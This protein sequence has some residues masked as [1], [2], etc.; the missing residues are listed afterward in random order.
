MNQIS[1]Q[2]H[3]GLL[4]VFEN[5]RFFKTDKRSFFI[6]LFFTKRSLTKESSL[7]IFNEGLSLSYIIAGTNF[8]EAK[9][10]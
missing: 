8:V 6:R 4:I 7:T 2:V 3:V 9:T 1:V 5:D 10:S